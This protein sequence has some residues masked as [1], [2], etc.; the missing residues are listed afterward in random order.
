MALVIWRLTQ[1]N[2]AL[3]MR[4]TQVLKALLLAAG[5]LSL[6]GAV[7]AVRNWNG[8]TQPVLAAEAQRTAPATGAAKPTIYFVKN[9][10]PTPAFQA[11]DLSGKTVS[12]AEWKG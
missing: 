12:A 3:D 2:K 7:W 8:A 1:H 10:E 5:I 9:P 4:G 6:I 11:K